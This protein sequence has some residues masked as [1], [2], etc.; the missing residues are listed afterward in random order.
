MAKIW[1]YED[2]I[3]TYNDIEAAELKESEVYI[4][5]Y[6]KPI[7]EIL[8]KKKSKAKLNLCLFIDSNLDLLES[9]S[10]SNLDGNTIQS[11]IHEMNYKYERLLYSYLK[12]LKFEKIQDYD[13]QRIKRIKE[14]MKENHLKTRECDEI[15]SAIPVAEYNSRVLKL[16][17]DLRNKR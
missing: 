2:G 16:S 3:M 13:I 1:L 5:D 9:L 12:Y 11:I 10:N 4:D 15:L 7:Y 17:N 14:I 8:I 6:F